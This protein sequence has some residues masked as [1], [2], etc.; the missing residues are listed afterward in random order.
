MKSHPVFFKDI[1][2]I[3]AIFLPNEVQY[4]VTVSITNKDTYARFVVSCG[5]TTNSKEIYIYVSCCQY[6]FS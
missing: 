3:R 2:H 6:S 1:S 4:I 5:E